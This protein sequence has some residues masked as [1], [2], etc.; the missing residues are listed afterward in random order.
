MA[1]P[2]KRVHTI[3]TED[4]T[5]EVLRTSADIDAEELL[6]ALSKAE[7]EKEKEAQ[8]LEEAL[9][10][11]AFHRARVEAA[12][13]IIEADRQAT[14]RIAA[15]IEPKN[16]EEVSG[17]HGSPPKKLRAPP[18]QNEPFF[19]DTTSRP[20]SH[21]D[22]GDPDLADYHDAWITRTPR[23]PEYKPPLK[24][25]PWRQPQ[26]E[27]EE[28]KEEMPRIRSPTRP[29]SFKGKEKG[30]GFEEDLKGKGKGKGFEEMFVPDPLSPPRRITLPRGA[31]PQI[32]CA[33]GIKG[34]FLADFCGNGV[35]GVCCRRNGFLLEDGTACEHK[36]REE[37]KAHRSRTDRGGRTPSKASSWS[38]TSWSTTSW[39]S[40]S[41][42]SE[43]QGSDSWQHW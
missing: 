28:V 29:P 12:E 21:V 2:S 11:Y 19:I 38:K 17:D 34:N 39:S 32:P 20:V 26:V 10:E 40:S 8:E 36:A 25:A 15:F 9:K 22:T 33:C 30:K 16:E 23:L 18:M 35:C 1:Q 24:C 6:D 3:Q 37:E 7:A 14:K 5:V 13:A 41:W 31:A 27:Q 4:F 42:S 43:A